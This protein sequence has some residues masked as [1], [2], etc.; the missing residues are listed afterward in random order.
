MAEQLAEL[1]QQ[2]AEATAAGDYD[3]LAPLANLWG[4]LAHP[5]TSAASVAAGG[6]AGGGGLSAQWNAFSIADLERIH[7]VLI[8]LNHIDDDQDD[9]DQDGDQ[10]YQDG[11]GGSSSR[12][13]AGPTG[14]GE[15]E[16]DEEEEVEERCWVHQ[17]LRNVGLDLA[18][19][20]ID[21]A[22][23]SNGNG[24][25]NGNGKPRGGGSD[26]PKRRG[27]G[28]GGGG[29]G[30]M[31]F[32]RQSIGEELS[33]AVALGILPGGVEVR[34]EA[35]ASLSVV[36][37]LVSYLSASPNCVRWSRCPQAIEGRRGPQATQGGG[38]RRGGGGG[39]AHGG[40]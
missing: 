34:Y 35:E 28:G 32:E 33:I 16:E 12:S 22:N 24:N 13:A 36:F 5:T 2:M 14:Q 15:G 8:D 23:G 9:D 7:R 25:G 31:K 3:R 18:G 30:G 20:D 1:E 4:R 39:A 40:Y 6:G 17:A 21:T 10:D 29:G 27:G 19:I 38:G 11:H 26:Y 37:L